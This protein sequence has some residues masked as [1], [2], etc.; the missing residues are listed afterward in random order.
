[1]NSIRVP[2]SPITP[3]AAYFA[4]VVSRAVSAVAASSSERSPVAVTAAAPLTNAASLLAVTSGRPLSV[5]VGNALFGIV[6]SGEAEMRILLVDDHE[7]VRKGIRVA[8]RSGT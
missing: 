8:A 3:M 1:M 6:Q 4:P 2:C 5:V 7:I